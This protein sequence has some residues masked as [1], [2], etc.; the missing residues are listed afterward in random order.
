VT[1]GLFARHRA[2]RCLLGTAGGVRCIDYPVL[3]P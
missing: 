1:V 3:K 2:S